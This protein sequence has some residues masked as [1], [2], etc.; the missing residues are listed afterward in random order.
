V[1]LAAVA[2]RSGGLQLAKNAIA[3]ASLR[4]PAPLV[5]PA[6]ETLSGGRVVIVLGPGSSLADYEAAGSRLHTRRRQPG[7]C[8]GTPGPGPRP[9]QPTS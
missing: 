2:G 9:G 7:G 3:L 8:T 4:G 5:L 6:R 1:A